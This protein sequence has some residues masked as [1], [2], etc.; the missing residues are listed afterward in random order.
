MEKISDR[1]LAEELVTRLN[2]LIEDPAVKQLIGRLIETRVEV[3]PSVAEHSTI[4]TVKV[5]FG[6][7]DLL[8]IQVWE[9]HVG[10]LGLLNGI[11][12][13]IPD[14]DHA[15][16]GYITSRFDDSGELLNFQLTEG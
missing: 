16:W 8:S 7:E 14:G 6:T 1:Q 11:V 15:H 9:D 12:G 10:F 4:Q 13:V 3:Q 5:H 2:K